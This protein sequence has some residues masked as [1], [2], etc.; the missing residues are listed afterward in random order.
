[1]SLPDAYHASRSRLSHS[2]ERDGTGYELGLFFVVAGVVLLVGQFY[3]PSQIVKNMK[4]RPPE[5]DTQ[6]LKINK[7]KIGEH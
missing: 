4:D 3:M 2:I 5:V 7:F 1:M 6:G